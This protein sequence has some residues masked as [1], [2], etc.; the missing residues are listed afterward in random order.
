M[1]QDFEYGT[2]VCL[3]KEEKE[4]KDSGRERNRQEKNM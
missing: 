1:D 4:G 3:K 2:Y